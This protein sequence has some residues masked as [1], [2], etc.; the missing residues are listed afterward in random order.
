[1]DFGRGNIVPITT[2][3]DNNCEKCH[4]FKTLTKFLILLEI[5]YN[6]Y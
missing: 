3:Y 2:S 4:V 1:M 5:L 6:L